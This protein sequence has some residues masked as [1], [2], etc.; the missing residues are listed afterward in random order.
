MIKLQGQQ[1]LSQVEIF[2]DY[3]W[4][5]KRN[6]LHTITTERCDY[7]ESR[8]DRVFGREAF[9]QQEVLEVGCGGGLLSEGMAERRVIV[10]GIDPSESSLQIARAHTQKSGLGQNTF[11]EQGYAESLPYADGSFSVIVCM[12]VLEHVQNLEAVIKEITRVLAPG[13]IFIFDTINRT[14]LARIALIWIGE[15]FF[16]KNGLVP[17]LHHYEKFIKPNELK[18]LLVKSG[19]KVH[20]MSG[21]MPAFKRGHLTLSPGWFKGASYVGYATKE[22]ST[23]LARSSYPL[24]T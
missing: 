20:E 16:Q 23:I 4:W 15:R 7:I 9:G 10:V 19:L 24:L 8:V 21:F 11:F 3:N 14:P 5:D 2:S 6:L 18:A 22:A 1:K 17:G 13:G 12:D